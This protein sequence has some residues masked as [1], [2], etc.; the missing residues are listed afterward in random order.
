VTGGAPHCPSCGAAAEPTRAF[1]PLPLMRCDSCGLVFAPGLDPADV[2]DRYAGDDYARDRPEHRE[3][4]PIFERIAGERVA[5][6]E[7]YA[8]NGALLEVGCA[9]GL[10]LRRAMERGFEVT[11]VEAAPLHVAHAR[12]LGVPVRE[13]FLEDLRL[14]PGSFEIACLFHVLEHVVEPAGLLEEVRRVLAPGGFAFIEVPNAD[15]AMARSKGAQWSFLDPANHP[16]H[17]SPPSLRRALDL[18]GFELLTM[19]TISPRLYLPRSRRLRLRPLLGYGYRSLRLRTLR[20]TH[21]SGHDLLRAVARRPP[22]AG[23]D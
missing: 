5:W 10:L 8:G 11:G 7:R 16:L 21:P 19:N 4:S 13:G 23:G 15:S 9:Q 12:E 18:A 22:E 14:D 17:F 3:G 2:R 1:V 6:V 20:S